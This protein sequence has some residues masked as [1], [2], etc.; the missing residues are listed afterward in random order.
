VIAGA[1]LL[2]ATLYMLTFEPA[3][4]RTEPALVRVFAAGGDYKYR[5][6][7]ADLRALLSQ[8]SN[9][10]LL[11]QALA[12]TLTYG[13]LV[14]MPRL[15]IA[16]VEATG[17]SLETA[18]MAGNLYSLL[19]QTGFYFAILA[20][21]VGDR[22]QRRDQRGRAW[23]GAFGM[24]GS[25]PF[26]MAVFFMPLRG[27]DLP[28]AGGPVPVS[29]AALLSIATNPWVAATFGLA[30]VS[31]A[32]ASVDIPN[33]NALLADVNLPEHRGTMA[34]LMALAIG[35]GVA[36][37]N[38]LT[39]LVLT[40]VSSWV[41]SPWNY[42]VGLALFQLFFIPAGLGYYQASRSIPGDMARVQYLLTKRAELTSNS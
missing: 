22:W 38:F 1:G 19:F 23:L 8:C 31:M 9:R 18:T 14:W 35:L 21:Y 24:L 15:F 7:W 5:I 12:A 17:Y 40:Q 39:G 26:Q 32:L 3:R 20:G 37:G 4:G 33:R 2:F 29:L 16:R 42:A 6:R 27:L 34:G 30:L 25:V 28:P 10:W 36:L 41:G 11:L 13:S